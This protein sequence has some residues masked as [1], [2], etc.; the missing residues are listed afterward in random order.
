MKKHISALDTMLYSEETRTIL[1]HVV[2]DPDLKKELAHA[3][4]TRRNV[5]RFHLKGGNSLFSI[6]DKVTLF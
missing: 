6:V 1:S 5:Y 3:D 2:R 4:T